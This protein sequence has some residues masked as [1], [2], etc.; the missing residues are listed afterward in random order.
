MPF[1][2]KISPKYKY[3]GNY[4]FSKLPVTTDAN[5]LPYHKCDARWYKCSHQDSSHRKLTVTGPLVMIVPILLLLIADFQRKAPQRNPLLI[6]V[7]AP[8]SVEEKNFF[9]GEGH[10]H[11][12]H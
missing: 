10:P 4:S 8:M 2:N 12:K 9:P 7:G 1:F 11:S 3:H 6:H 5:L